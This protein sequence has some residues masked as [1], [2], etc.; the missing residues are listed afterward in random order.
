MCWCSIGFDVCTGAGVGDSAGA[1]VC[2]FEGG[3]GVGVA[4]GM[5]VGV[6]VGVRVSLD[7]GVSVTVVLV[8]V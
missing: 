2:W 4:F 3:V 8:L 1:S 6:T 7:V 5:T